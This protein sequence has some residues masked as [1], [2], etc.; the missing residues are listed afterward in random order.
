MSSVSSRSISKI[1]IVG[2]GIGGLTAAI[3]L[4]KAGFECTVFEQTPEVREVGA[5]ITLWENALRVYG[6]LGL[7]DALMARGVLLA[8]GT[9]GTSNGKNLTRMR[10]SEVREKGVAMEMLGVHRGA[11]QRVLLDALPEES[12][13]LG[14]RV[15]TI[16]EDADRVHLR[17]ENGAEASGD[18]VIGADGVHSVVRTH[19]LG[20]H[21]PRY[22]GY[23]CWR[24][25]GARFADWQG[26]TGEF[27]GG[28]H[29][30]GLIPIDEER[31]YWFAV[32]T[33]PE[34]T[35]DPP[36]GRKERLLALYEGWQ[37]QIPAVIEHTP[38]EAIMHN[39]IADHP[40]I[41]GWSRGRI[42]LLGDSAHATTPNMGQ[43]AC[44]AIE[45]AQ[46]LA[47]LL[48]SDHALDEALR[49]Y[50]A[51]RAPRTAMI[52]KQSWTIGKVGHWKNPIACW[53]RNLMMRMIPGSMQT[54][55]MVK[56]LGYDATREP[57]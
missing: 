47:N 43:G 17:F 37:H 1:L 36:E 22:A 53:L 52:T 25:V 26:V 18:L 29:R 50:E 56:M 44:M 16:A 54:K 13:R 34:G 49:L 27:W 31:I 48:Q 2:G 38:P 14:H 15:V 24:G 4:R 12:V 20:A 51:N 5:G 40:P 55:Q 7:R 45:S 57:R 19:L 11:L 28:G 33:A 10:L 30:F 32:K 46:V 41:S 9:L 3:A 21:T 42:T 39:D 6:H 8:D 23:T 35:V